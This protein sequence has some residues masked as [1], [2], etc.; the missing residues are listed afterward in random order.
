MQ[1]FSKI[2]GIETNFGLN[3]FFYLGFL[4][5]TFTN[6]W[7]AQEE[8]GYFFISSLPHPPTS[9]TLGHYLHL[10]I[11]FTQITDKNLIFL[12]KLV[13]FNIYHIFAPFVKLYGCRFL[14]F[15]S[16]CDVS[17]KAIFLILEHS[18][19]RGW[20]RKRVKKCKILTFKCLL[21]EIRLKNLTSRKIFWRPPWFYQKSSTDPSKGYPHGIH[22]I[23]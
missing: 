23:Q 19:P 7:T 8:G 18:S 14:Y 1:N 16:L 15:F 21:Q 12:Q 22:K 6:H 5:W 17:N 13:I 3:S 4:S 9:Q 11:H 2:W 20:N 10:D